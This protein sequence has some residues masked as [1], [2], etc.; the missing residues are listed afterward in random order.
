MYNSDS[1][2]KN[3]TYITITVNQSNLCTILNLLFGFPATWSAKFHHLSCFLDLT[4]NSEFFDQLEQ[5]LEVLLV[6][7]LLFLWVKNNLIG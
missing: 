1:L 4:N 6:Y 3:C 2:Q 5:V 7:L